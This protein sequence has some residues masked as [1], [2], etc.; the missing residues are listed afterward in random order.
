VCEV[1][2]GVVVSGLFVPDAD[3]GVAIADAL[4]NA[5]LP[6]DVSVTVID[7]NDGGLLNPLTGAPLGAGRMFVVAGGSFGQRAVA[8]AEDTGVA[9]VTAL[10]VGTDL[11]IIGPD[12]G[13]LT[14]IPLSQFSAGRDY[15]VVQVIRT[16]RGSVLFNTHGYF[17]PGTAAGA[18]WVVNRMLPMRTLQTSRWYVYDWE[19]TNTNLIADQGDTFTALASGQ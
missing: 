19:D 2:T 7:Q 1:S 10:E 17:G 14:T 3:A 12:G 11:N 5:C 6:R 9:P 13:T 16:P 4:I 15:F 18:W 8:W